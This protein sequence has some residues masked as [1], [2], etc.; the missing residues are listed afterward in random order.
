MTVYFTL[1][2]HHTGD[3]WLVVMFENGAHLIDPRFWSVGEYRGISYASRAGKTYHSPWPTLLL[4]RMRFRV[5]RV[6]RRLARKARR[7]A[8]IQAIAD[9]HG[10]EPTKENL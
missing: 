1:T 10:G 4:W 5:W 8:R 6:E 3:R 9:K 7:Q 2:G